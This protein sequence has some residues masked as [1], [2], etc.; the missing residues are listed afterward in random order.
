MYKPLL[1]DYSEYLDGNKVRYQKQRK[2]IFHWLFKKRKTRMRESALGEIYGKL[3]YKTET[4]WKIA[5]KDINENLVK[6]PMCMCV[7][8]QN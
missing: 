7:Y 6:R 1:W 3:L 2:H 4:F 8:K 5:G